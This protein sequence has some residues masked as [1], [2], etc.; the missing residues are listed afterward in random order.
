MKATLK[1]VEAI[2]LFVAELNGYKAG[3]S[4]EDKYHYGIKCWMSNKLHAL[5]LT[6]E[7]ERK[8]LYENIWLERMYKDLDNAFSLVG[9][10]GDIQ[11]A[12]YLAGMD[13]ELELDENYS[14]TVP[15]ELD[16]AASMLQIMGVLLNDYD[17]CNATN[18]IEGE[19]TDPW[20]V[21][22]LTRKMVKIAATPMLYGS[23]K[24]CHELWQADEEI[25]YDLDD[26]K[27]YNE[28]LSTGY[29]AKANA[30]KNF[31]INN[32][33]PTE[34]M[35]IHL[36]E[37]KFEVHCNRYKQVGETTKAFDIFDTNSQA[38]KRIF[39]TTTKGVADLDQF[40]RYFP[41]LCVHGIDS[42]IMNSLAEYCMDEFG[43]AID[44]HDAII[45]DPE[46]AHLVRAKYS[47]IIGVIHKNRKEILANYF[48]SI[49]IR[50]T[51]QKQ[52]EDLQAMVVPL[53]D[54]F[55]CGPM[56]MK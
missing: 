56:A 15:V 11:K 37:D 17:L 43:W 30:F 8:D 49:G 10:D 36:W 54:D 44:I 55:V 39:H 35:Q 14:W 47:E 53:P 26:V 21:V 46:V 4:M 5:N 50:G 33:Q 18:M 16:C 28:A 25:S 13:V 3:P 2:A 32:A 40:R 34:V 23:S 42:Q 12:M 29:L 41:T 6:I 38:I 45:V 7:K 24:Q 9:I 22:G 1:G 31:L 51:A 19:L 27:T 52:W 20:S 48:K